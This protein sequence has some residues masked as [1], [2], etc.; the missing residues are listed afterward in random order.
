MILILEVIV[1]IT[2]EFKSLGYNY[3]NY[4][5]INQYYGRKAETQLEE[6]HPQAV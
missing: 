5:E 3:C 2:G 6:V 4:D 1:V